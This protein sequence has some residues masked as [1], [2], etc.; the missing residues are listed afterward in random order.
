M[1]IISRSYCVPGVLF[2]HTVV[3]SVFTC[4]QCSPRSRLLTVASV[5]WI[6]DLGSSGLITPSTQGDGEY[7]VH[8][9]PVDAAGNVG[10]EWTYVWWV[11]TGLP[12]APRFVSTPASVIF[13]ETAL[14]EL[15]LTGDAS[16]GQVRGVADDVL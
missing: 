15:Q 9:R 16:P 5:L 3:R 8:V 1:C 10:T 2:V 11:D 14:F 4:D 6:D 13:T 12:A 7:V